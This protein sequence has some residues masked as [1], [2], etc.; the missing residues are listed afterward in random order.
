MST[1]KVKVKELGGICG[2]VQLILVSILLFWGL[3]CDKSNPVDNNG[4]NVIF[5][6][7]SDIEGNV[8]KTVMIGNQEW[9][10]ENLRVTKYNNGTAI[11]LVTG[12][13]EW[14]ALSTPGYCYYLNTANTDSIKKW[15]ALYNWYVVSPTN[16]NK[17]APAG[18]HVPTDAE[19]TILE[20]YLVL[21]GYN[22]DGT[23]TGNKIAKSLSS[24]SN[25]VISTSPGAIGKDLTTNNRSGF[26]ALP[27]GLRNANG[28]FCD[29]S[30]FGIWWCVTENDASNALDRQL[31]NCN[32]NIVW[33]DNLKRDGYSLRLLRDLKKNG[34]Q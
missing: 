18:W 24:N 17:I 4:D 32:D 20:K 3:S 1:Q 12:I 6:T 13:S 33:S 14:A 2:S 9:M 8:Y 16:T 27:G 31:G 26:T 21:N 34:T 29:Q 25:W 15:G 30:W 22:W 11:P 19:W 28:Y 10:A 23:T 7:M 5:G